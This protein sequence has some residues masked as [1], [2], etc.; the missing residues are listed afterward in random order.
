MTDFLRDRFFS[1]EVLVLFVLSKSNKGLNVCLEEFFAGGWLAPSKSAFTQARRKLCYSVFK[2]LNRLVCDLFYRNAKF[3]KWKGH[4]VLSVDGSTLNLPNHPSMAEKFSQHG[5]GPNADAKHFMSRISYLYDVFNGLVLD[6]GMESYTTSEATL[7]HGHLEHVGPGDILICDRYYAS[8]RIFFEL[9]A[10]GADFLFRMKDSWWDCVKEFQNGD[11]P[12]AEYT[13][14]LPKKDRWI[15][16]QYPG[17]AD[18]ITVRLI[19]KKSSN[20]KV[21]VYATSLLDRKKYPIKSLVNLYKQRWGIEEAYKLIKSRLDVCD[22][23]GKTALAVQQDFYAKTLLLSLCNVLCHRVEPKTK[24]GKKTTSTRT[25]IL[26]RTYALFQTKA[27]IQKL[28]STLGQIEQ[29]IRE[30]V[31]AIATKTEYSKRGQVYKRKFK[32]NLKYSMNYKSI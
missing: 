4:R 14:S 10:K 12:E 1:F 24:T 6:S 7:C 25:L 29:Y 9:K 27:L 8:L 21:S 32:P 13:L 17:T 23:S 11:S 3:K 28:N 30:A 22:F 5:F 19:R 16:E 15:L 2:K 20:G 26:N 18:T 31:N